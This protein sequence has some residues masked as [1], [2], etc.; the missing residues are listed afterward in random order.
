MPVLK[1]LWAPATQSAYDFGQGRAA[2][3]LAVLKRIDRE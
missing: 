2:R 3:K 1:Q